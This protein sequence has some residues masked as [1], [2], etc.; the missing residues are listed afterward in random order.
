[1]IKLY[2][3]EL[4]FSSSSIYVIASGSNCTGPELRTGC[5]YCVAGVFPAVVYP[6]YFP[7]WCLG[8]TSRKTAALSSLE[9]A[10]LRLYYAIVLLSSLLLGFYITD[11]HCLLGRMIY[12]QIPYG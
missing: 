4:G 11:V 6:L 12:P 8:S 1:M 10:S 9:I 7:S 2:L 5:V 3:E